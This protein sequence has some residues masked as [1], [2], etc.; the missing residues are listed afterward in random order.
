MHHQIRSQ[1][2]H[3]YTFIAVTTKGMKGR[4][5]WKTIGKGFFDLIT[6]IELAW[7][8]KLKLFNTASKMS[9]WESLVKFFG[10]SDAAQGF[11][12]FANRMVDLAFGLQSKFTGGVKKF[13]ALYQKFKHGLEMEALLAKVGDDAARLEVLLAKA[14]DDPAKLRKV[15][16]RM[17]ADEFEES[18]KHYDDVTKMLEDLRN[19]GNK[20]D[21]FVDALR[22]RRK[23]GEE[24]HVKSDEE[25]KPHD[26][27]EQKPKTD[28]DG[29]NNKKDN[30]EAEKMAALAEAKALLAIANAADEPLPVLQLQLQAVDAQYDAVKR[31][32]Y[33]P[34]GDDVE[35]W[36]IGSKHFVGRLDGDEHSN[37]NEED[38]T[39]GFYHGPKPEYVNPGHHEKGPNFRGGGSMTE[40]IPSNHQELWSKAIPGKQVF[41]SGTMSGK[42]KNWYA[43]DENGIIHRFT[44]DNNGLAHWNGSQAGDRGL[45]GALAKENDVVKRLNKMYNYLFE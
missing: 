45:S 35:V 33:V 3:F 37:E 36:L 18:M 10:K 1:T 7:L 21:E 40:V 41:E 26:T 28:D 25:V 42:P 4:D 13:Q 11:V 34:K 16:R 44:V 5:R 32:E 31:F 8:S 9:K 39:E 38:Y 29:P 17:S 20:S 15:L 23:P 12:K 2:L 19:S 24:P 27:P 43:I 30:D 14:G 22:N 6:S